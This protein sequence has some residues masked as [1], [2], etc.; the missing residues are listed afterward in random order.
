[1]VLQFFI[2]HSAATASLEHLENRTWS[3]KG[4][5][6]A[7]FPPNPQPNPHQAGWNRQ[8]PAG[9]R[10]DGM[11]NNLKNEQI[12]AKAQAD[13]KDKKNQS[14]TVGSPT[15]SVKMQAHL[16]NPG[17][18]FFW[19]KPRCSKVSGPVMHWGPVYL[20]IGF[21]HAAHWYQPVHRVGCKTRKRDIPNL[22]LLHR[23][24]MAIIPPSLC[25]FLRE[26]PHFFLF[27]IALLISEHP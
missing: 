16:P 18:A 2:P 1:M 21:N 5:R 27:F 11:G 24:P 6:T 19:A 9:G 26:I 20:G 13:V 12:L 25:L 7:P 22:L 3:R 23:L 10:P 4:S 8:L 17:Q 15:Q 14:H